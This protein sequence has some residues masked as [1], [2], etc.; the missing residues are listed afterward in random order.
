[1]FLQHSIE[2][3]PEAV[4]KLIVCG[5]CK[6]HLPFDE[7]LSISYLARISETQAQVQ[8]SL[9]CTECILIRVDPE[10]RA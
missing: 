4:G 7:C 9:V 2:T 3:F 5:G 10:G 6:K 1:M 8:M